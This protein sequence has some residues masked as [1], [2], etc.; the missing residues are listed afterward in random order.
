MSHTMFGPKRLITAVLAATVIPM[1]IAVPMGMAIASAGQASAAPDNDYCDLIARQA[2]GYAG[3][4]AEH[5][6]WVSRGHMAGCW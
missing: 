4:D 5:D 1:A 2:I 3:S 6:W